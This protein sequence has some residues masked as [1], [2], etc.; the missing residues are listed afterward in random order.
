MPGLYQE[1]H[2][3][4]LFTV[5]PSQE[6]RRLQE[7][8]DQLSLGALP[9]P[10]PHTFRGRSRTLLAL[11]RLLY[12]QP[13]AVVSGPGGNG[14]TA[15]VVELVRWLMR[16]ARFRRAAFVSL[17]T[18]M[19]ARGV[20]DSLGRQLLLED[21]KYS[22]AQYPDLK[23][24]LQPVQRALADQPT[25]IVLDNMESVLPD[26]GRQAPVGA[27]PIGELLQLCQDFLDAHASTRLIFTSREALPA[28][29]NRHHRPLSTLERTDAID[30]VSQVLA[31]E[32]L[33]PHP[34]D[35]GETPQEISDL[36]EAVNCHPRALVLLAR[37][38]SR[39]GVRATTENLQHLMAELERRHPGDRENSLYASVELSLRRLSAEIREQAHALPVVH[40]GANLHVLAL[41]LEVTEDTARKLAIALIDVGLAEDR[42]YGHLRLDPALAP[43]LLGQT[44]AAEQERLGTRW[45]E[46]MQQLT[47]FLYGQIFEDI[48]IAS[49]M[50]VQELP[51]LLALLSWLQKKATLE[52][53]VDVAI[54]MEKL[55]AIS[56]RPQVLAQ[57]VKVREQVMRALEEWSH[58]QFAGEA[59]NIE[60]LLGRGD[61]PAAHTAAHHLLECSQQSGESA[62]PDAA[63]DIAGAHF[64]FGRVQQC[65]GA[66]ETALPYLR[67][68]QRR[69][70]HLAAG[71][72]TN[73]VR[74]AY[75]ALTEQGDCF[76]DLGR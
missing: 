51:N 15:L 66:S 50:T 14:K 44:D 13:Y 35:S 64:L 2:D 58:A 71:G 34:N 12:T 11:E 1:E 7:R 70:Q 39:Q 56:G 48:T 22:V 3:P 38:V 37:E 46:E 67:E 59:Q 40:G 47:D 63:Y 32:G 6:A 52:V 61:L 57:I 5:L 54:A 62:Y 30:L 20:L 65:S 41:V 10:P 4:Q 68:A 43:Y 19:D 28:P 16:T 60:R 27:T 76:K 8:Q 53:V 73:A 72:H 23:R 24:A 29:F 18:Y 69:F 45:A 55:L 49:Q 21:D 74:M 36:V 31:Q 9:N 25:L 33:S 42:G 75:R 17:E 26:A